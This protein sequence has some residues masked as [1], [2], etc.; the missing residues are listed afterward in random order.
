MLVVLVVSVVPG[1]EVILKVHLQVS[2]LGA[3]MSQESIGKVD[4]FG[5]LTCD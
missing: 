5:V 3:A 1:G 4:L 2:L